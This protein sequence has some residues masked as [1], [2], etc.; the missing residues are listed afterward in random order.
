[1]LDIVIDTR[2][3]NPFSFPV[4]LARCY[5]KGLKAGDYALLGDE[6]NFAIERKSLDDFTGTI[7]RGWNR[8]LREIDRMKLL[9]FPSK[10]IIVEADM[11]EF[12]FGNNYEPQHQNRITPQFIMKRIAELAMLDVKVYFACDSSLGA[13]LCYAILKERRRQIDEINNKNKKSPVSKR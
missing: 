7:S 4:H 11:R 6:L 2:E 13:G 1:M 8:F 12:C 3:Q 10:I 9:K 5:R